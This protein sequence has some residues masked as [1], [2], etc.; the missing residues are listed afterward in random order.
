MA[1][2]FRL[3]QMPASTVRKSARI[4]RDDAALFSGN[5]RNGVRDGDCVIADMAIEVPRSQQ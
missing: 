5:S 1:A 2:S 4:R 3:D